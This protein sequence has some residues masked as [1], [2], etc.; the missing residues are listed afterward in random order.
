[1]A[2]RLDPTFVISHRLQLE[3]AAKGYEMFV[4]KEDRCEKVVLKAS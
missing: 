3:D 1:M 4:N 2:G